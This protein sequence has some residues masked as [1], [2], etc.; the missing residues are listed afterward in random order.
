MTLAPTFK[1]YRANIK[2]K[3]L[4]SKAIEV[5]FDLAC[6]TVYSFY[7]TPFNQLF[8][9]HRDKWEVFYRRVVFYLVKDKGFKYKDIVKIAQKKLSTVKHHHVL[10]GYTFSFNFLFYNPKS[11]EAEI[12]KKIETHYK[13]A[14]KSYDIDRIN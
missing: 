3:E 14:L 4:S 2:Q 5:A 9:N 13:L 10:D 6:D 8:S 12:I 1:F 7:K 11:E